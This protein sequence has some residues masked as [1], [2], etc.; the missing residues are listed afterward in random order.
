M[1]GGGGVEGGGVTVVYHVYRIQIDVFSILLF[2]IQ[3]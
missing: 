1:C 2:S 3:H